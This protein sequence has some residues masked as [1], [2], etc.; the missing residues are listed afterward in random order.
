MIAATV[1]RQLNALGLG[2]YDDP[3]GDTNIFLHDLPPA[4][5]DAI[6]VWGESGQT[7]QTFIRRGGFQIIVRR[8]PHSPEGRARS[9][10]DVAREILDALASADHAVWADDTDDALRVAW[11]QPQQAEPLDLGPDENG[12]PKWS[13]R[14]TYETNGASA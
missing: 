11:C 14:F 3:D 6:G 1:A 7:P 10:H 4:P 9:G 8:D 13:V 12:A 5:V 2:L